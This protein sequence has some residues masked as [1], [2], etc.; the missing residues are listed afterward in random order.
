MIQLD[1]NYTTNNGNEVVIYT[2]S[3]GGDFPVHAGVVDKETKKI[4]MQTYSLHGETPDDK[5]SD[6]DIVFD[7][8]DLGHIEGETCIMSNEDELLPVLAIF[9]RAERDGFVGMVDLGNG[10]L[11]E[12]VFD[13]VYSDIKELDNLLID[14]IKDKAKCKEREEEA[15]ST[16]QTYSEAPAIEALFDF[17]R[18][19]QAS[20]R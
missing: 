14:F 3:A 19:I 5:F 20:K 2:I 13:T 12:K 16:E 7:E 8:D 18:K 4:K 6:L 1:K 17:I 9:K 11:E 15:V 10:K